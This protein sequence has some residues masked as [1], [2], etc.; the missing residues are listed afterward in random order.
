MRY[1]Y[2][3]YNDGTNDRLGLSAGEP[4]DFRKDVASFKEI[5]ED[6]WFKEIRLDRGEVV[7]DPAKENAAE[8]R[9]E[10]E[11]TAELAR[12]AARTAALD[13]LKRS[14]DQGIRDLLEVLGL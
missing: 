3:E 4:T 7:L 12:Q 2:V 6:L 11:R 13:R 1:F 14:A 10:A 5:P 8:Q 9:R